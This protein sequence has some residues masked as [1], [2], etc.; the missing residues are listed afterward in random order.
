MSMQNP[1]F[2]S[3]PVGESM[4]GPNHPEFE[5]P[6]ETSPEL[7]NTSR[8]KR[9]S[10]AKMVTTPEAD[11]WASHDPNRLRHEQKRE[12]AMIMVSR[13]ASWKHQ[14]SGPQHPVAEVYNHQNAPQADSNVIHGPWEHP[15][16]RTVDVAPGTVIQGPWPPQVETQQHNEGAQYDI[17][18]A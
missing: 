6:R 12:A 17:P 15:E 5:I 14:H 7:M 10:L 11:L 8:M 9:T 16:D 4:V 1:L 3:E 13:A 2:E 18:A